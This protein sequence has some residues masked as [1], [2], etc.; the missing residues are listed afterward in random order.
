MR[1]HLSSFVRLA[2]AAA[3]LVAAGTLTGAATPARGSAAPPLPITVKFTATG[4][5]SATLQAGS[6]PDTVSEALQWA[7]ELPATIDADGTITPTGYG[8]LTDGPGTF[9][10]QDPTYSVSCTGALPVASGAAP[11]V[12]AVNGSTI[13]AQSFTAVD[14]DGSSGGYDSCQGIAPGSGLPYDGSQDAANLA[15]TMDE[16]MPDVMSAKVDVPAKLSGI[17]TKQVTNADAPAQLPS[18]CDDQ[19]GV[20]CSMSLHWSGQVQ[21]IPACGTVTFSEGGAL[22]VGTI[23]SIGQTIT[24]GKGQRLEITLPDSSIVRFGP[25]SSALCN[26]GCDGFKAEERGFSFKLLLG[27]MWAKISTGGEDGVESQHA[28]TGVRGSEMTASAHGKA[29][30]THVVEGVGFVHVI[31][32]PEIHYPAGLGMRIVGG[33]ATI[34]DQWPRADQAVVPASDRPPALTRVR[35]SGARGEPTERLLFNLD[36][37]SKMTVQVLRGKKVVLRSSGKGRKG[38]NALRPFKHALKKGSYQI[39]VTATANNGSTTVL[40]MLK[41]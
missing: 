22:P 39:R 3:A 8:T 2:V 16:Y 5:F 4:T 34:T 13:T 11:P 33:K 20:P 21:V 17:F 14:Q 18:S 32:K 29:V 9:T 25:E 1:R 24:T 23:V 19:F 41:V 10:Y 15:G 12:L 36:Q 27:E 40:L 31:G 26:A 38:K 37:A 7:S 30:L 6:P 28:C 35:L